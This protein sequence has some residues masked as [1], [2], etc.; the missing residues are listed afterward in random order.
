MNIYKRFDSEKGRITPIGDVEG[1]AFGFI[2]DRDAA[3]I[4]SANAPGC[5]AIVVDTFT[6]A[7]CDGALQ[8]TFQM[9]RYGKELLMTSW[10]GT[11]TEKTIRFTTHASFNNLLAQYSKDSRWMQV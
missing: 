6:Y 9:V 10:D 8:R 11:E 5:K 1:H 3:S 7:A 4:R 2:G